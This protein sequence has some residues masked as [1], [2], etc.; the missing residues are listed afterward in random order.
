[1]EEAKMNFRDTC[2]ELWNKTETITVYAAQAYDYVNGDNVPSIGIRSFFAEYPNNDVKIDDISFMICGDVY[3]SNHKKVTDIHDLND[4]WTSNSEYF[5]NLRAVGGF[6]IVTV[7][8]STYEIIKK[9]SKDS[10]GTITMTLQR[11]K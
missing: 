3:F 4:S 11:R 7:D 5:V 8:L 6:P 1:M 10:K 9:S 2:L